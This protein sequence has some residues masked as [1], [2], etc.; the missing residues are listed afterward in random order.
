MAQI[1]LNSA[2][3][4]L[5]AAAFLTTTAAALR[6]EPQKVPVRSTDERR[7]NS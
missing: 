7:P 2:L 6:G 3:A 5:V 4:L 1:I